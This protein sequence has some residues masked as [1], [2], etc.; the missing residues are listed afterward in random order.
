VQLPTLL[1]FLARLVN[2]GVVLT[3]AALPVA[4]GNARDTMV[5]IVIAVS[6]SFR[7]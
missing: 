3:F 1:L 5:D 7:I 6:Y 2:G 4:S